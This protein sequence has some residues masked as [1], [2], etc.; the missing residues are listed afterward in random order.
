MPK[1]SN[2]VHILL[3]DLR[4]LRPGLVNDAHNNN[5][6]GAG[7]ICVTLELAAPRK[8]LILLVIWSIFMIS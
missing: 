8:L 7:I 5:I 2:A 1:P 4:G 3:I 6:A